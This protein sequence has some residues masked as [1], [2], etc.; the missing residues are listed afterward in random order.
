MIR[1]PPRSTLFPYTTLFRSECAFLV[2]LPQEIARD[3][4]PDVGVRESVERADPLAK[5]RN[6][7]LLNLHDLNVGRSAR[8]HSRCV[9]W[10]RRSN[11]QADDDQEKRAAY[12][13]FVFQKCVHVFPR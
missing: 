3:L 7:L 6:I 2:A 4:C 10:A 5:N 9:L 1:R 8:L 13:E 12:P 11:N